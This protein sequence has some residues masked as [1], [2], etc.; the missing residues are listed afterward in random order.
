MLLSAGFVLKC[1]KVVPSTLVSKL[2]TC[3]SIVYTVNNTS[4]YFPV[5][6]Q[7]LKY[8]FVIVYRRTNIMPSF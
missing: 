8:L 7:K 1:I 5:I 6:I 2:Y 3:I 4:K